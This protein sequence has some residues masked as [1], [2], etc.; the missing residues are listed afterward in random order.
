M[1]TTRPRALLAAALLAAT[2]AI[3]AV[4]AG[5]AAAAPTPTPPTSVPTTTAPTTPT[6]SGPTLP[7]PP[8]GPGAP[9]GLRVTAISPG[10]VTLSWTASTVGCCAIAGYSIGYSQAFNDLYLSQWAGDVTTVTITGGIRGAT[11]FNFGVSARDV[12]GRSSPSAYLRVI[13]PATTTGDTTP[14]VAPSNLLMTALTP[15][16][17]ALTW[18]A[19]TDDVGVTGYQVYHFDGWYTSTLVGTTTG[20]SLVA[21]YGTSG[22]SMHYFYVRATD[23]AGNL[24]LASST[25]RAP[26]PSTPTPT[27]SV[28]G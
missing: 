21:P 24:S 13:T 22:T 12:E 14:P 2:G 4:T 6:P 15:A 19:S 16:G 3:V 23:A 11:Q 10:S 7:P 5:R 1:P 26:T 9:T 20:T 18:S 28:G 8:P 17:A 25:V 27:P